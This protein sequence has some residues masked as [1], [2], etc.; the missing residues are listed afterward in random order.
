MCVG[1]SVCLYLHY[2]GESC[3]CIMC[4]VKLGKA[5]I[6]V[7]GIMVFRGV[8]PLVCVLLVCGVRARSMV[9]MF[10]MVS[11]ALFTRMGQVKR[12]SSFLIVGTSFPRIFFFW[13]A[14][15]TSL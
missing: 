11:G 15:A 7:Y 2:L 4:S 5:G 9:V 10:R 13:L 1:L 3:A 8:S 12:R 14:M 6:N